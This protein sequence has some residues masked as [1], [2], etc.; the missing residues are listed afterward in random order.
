MDLATKKYTMRAGVFS[1][2]HYGCPF[3]FSTMKR[4]NLNM[5]SNI[6][7]EGFFQDADGTYQLF[8]IPIDLSGNWDGKEFALRL[9]TFE[10]DYKGITK[11][12]DIDPDVVNCD[13]PHCRMCL[14]AAKYS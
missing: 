4:G 2:L 6:H 11:E 3:L 5:A 1:H 13:C 14:P 9:E 12:Y 8:E 10:E 7:T